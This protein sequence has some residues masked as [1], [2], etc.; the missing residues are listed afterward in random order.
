MFIEI[1]KLPPEGGPIQAEVPGELLELE[2][3]KFARADGP[4]Q[5]DLFAYVVSHELIVKGTLKA[6]VKL[7]CG[8]CAEFF[9]TFLT[10]SSFLRAYPISEGVDKVDLSEDIR[11]DIL[12]D[13][14]T[15][16]AC[17]WKGEGVCP[18]SGVDLDEMKRYERPPDDNPWGI[19]DNLDRK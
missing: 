12:V 15:Y 8:R 17:P 2:Q 10:V 4:I 13:M 16:P 14:P 11:E 18:F 3:D 5:V 1:A 19:L 9:S 7:L 6:P